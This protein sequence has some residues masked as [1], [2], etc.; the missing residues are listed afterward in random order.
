MEKLLIITYYWPPSGGPGVQR[1]LKFSGYLKRKGFDPIILT[2]D[3]SQ[4]T[5]PVADTTLQDK[6]P[7]DLKVF[8]TPTREP[9]SLYKRLTGRTQVP[10]SG[11]TNESGTGFLATLSRFIRGNI[12]VPDARRGWNSFA[13]R[14]ARQL[15][16]E[17]DIR[18]VITTS[19]PHSTQLVGLRLKKE[20]PSLHWI[21]DLR[22]PWTD[23][24]YYNKMLHLPFIKALD[25]K[26]EKKVLRFA[27]I[28]ITVGENIR[29]KLIKKVGGGYS[30]KFFVIHNGYDPEDFANLPGKTSIPGSPVKIVYTGTISDEYD[31]TG[32]INALEIYCN[33]TEFS[34]HFI[35]N[36]SHKWRTLLDNSF[37]GQ[38]NIYPHMNHRD[39]IIQMYSADVLLLVI[40][41]IEQNEGIV[42]GKLFEYMATHNPVLGIGPVDGDAAAILEETGAGMMFRYDDI[43]GILEFLSKG[44][45]EVRPGEESIEAFSRERLTEKLIRLF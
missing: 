26:L 3:P 24:F 15:I 41:R 40:P 31:M 19:P 13:I 11:F 6:I 32:F 7:A 30:E 27:G 33:T 45:D 5:Y 17:H 2:V 43:H 34:L 44:K 20:F 35:G 25:A 18:V 39:A 4:A 16:Q 1:W 28:V 23:I 36:I 29:Q 14:K 10:Y 12:F 42:T 37:P 9:Y 38:V 21:A 8:H 22:D